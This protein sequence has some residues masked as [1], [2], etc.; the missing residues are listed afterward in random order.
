MG[1][2]WSLQAPN[3]LCWCI[4]NS[5]NKVKSVSIEWLHNE[6]FCVLCSSEY[7]KVFI[8]LTVVKFSP[9]HGIYAGRLSQ[10]IYSSWEFWLPPI[11][12][13]YFL[14]LW[15]NGKVKGGNACLCYAAIRDNLVW[16]LLEIAPW[17]LCFLAGMY[18]VPKEIA[19]LPSLRELTDLQ[20]PRC[21]NVK[22]S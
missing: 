20:L 7:M 19:G 22:V 18:Q 3:L 21:T 5:I 16:W 17:G 14:M 8:R 12:K 15:T 6:W 10:R 13:H 9:F 4:T 2:K 11:P 1:R